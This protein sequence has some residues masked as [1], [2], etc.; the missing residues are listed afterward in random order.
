MA[1][2]HSDTTNARGAR[3]V[4]SGDAGLMQGFN[5]N[6][7]AVFASV[8]KAPFTTVVDRVAGT[9]TVNI[10]SF[11]PSL[12]LV[13]PEGATHFKIV[14]AGSEVDF[15]AETYNTDTQETAILPWDDTMTAL[16][17]QVLTVTAGTVLPLFI[18]VGVLFYEQVN[19]NYYP[20]KNNKFNPLGVVK[21]D[22]V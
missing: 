15:A 14:S 19:G 17:N 11:D 10:P 22:H 20:L 9:M 13:A 4:A 12:M 2:V 6:R 8:F 7:H 21:V 3:D 5:Y 18:N 16:I 1:V